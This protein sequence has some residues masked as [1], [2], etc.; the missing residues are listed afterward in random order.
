MAE[1][2][3]LVIAVLGLA[4]AFGTVL[5]RNLVH[6][7]LY[8]IG[9]FFTVAC[10]FVLLEAEFLAAIQVLVYIGAVA[11]LLIFGIMLT[12]NIQGDDT[13]TIPTAWKVPGLFAGFCLFVILVFGINNAV[14]PSGKGTW[15]SSTLRP[16]IA[17]G[18]GPEP[19]WVTERRQSINDMARMVGVQLMTRYAVAF[20]V[21]GLLLTA[22]LVGA[23]ALAHREEDDPTPG[24][25]AAMGSQSTT[26]NGARG[27]G[28][29]PP[30]VASSRSRS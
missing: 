9:F 17:V 22:A 16:S 28:S 21:A 2:L 20:E 30:A 23:I 4:S 7:A 12:R 8:L 24:R 11:I 5:A 18:Q 25:S 1:F 13:T 29:T 26:D 10:M 6:A 19:A 27:A 3:F 14:A 15:S